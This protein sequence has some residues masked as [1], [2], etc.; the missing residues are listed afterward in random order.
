MSRQ[1]ITSSSVVAAVFLVFPLAAEDD[2]GE[3][4]FDILP[5][6]NGSVF[7]GQIV[8]EDRDAVYFKYVVR[9]P[10]SPT[11][12]FETTFSRDEV[13]WKKVRRLS[14]EERKE[15]A[16]RIEML[17]Q[18]GKREQA[19]MRDL[20]LEEIKF[21]GGAGW[22]YSSKYFRLETN[23]REELA[24]E[25]I[26][27]LEDV[28][29]AYTHRLGARRTPKEVTRIT[30]FRSV[31]DYQ[32]AIQELR[33]NILNPAFYDPV[34]NWIM[35]A[36]ALEQQAQE[37]DKL[38]QKHDAIL[39]DLEEQEKKMRKHY[40]GQPPQAMLAQF[41]QIR[42]NV[43][44]VNAEN[45]DAF[46]AMKRPL[47]AILY[48]E[49]FHAYLDNHVYPSSEMTVPRWLNEGLAQIFET[50]IVEAG[51]LRVGHVHPKRL[52]KI[53][54]ALKNKQIVPLKELLTSNAKPFSVHDLGDKQI[55]DRYF[56]TSWA[57]AYYLAFER[58]ALDAN[59]LD[60][61]VNTL[62]RGTDPLDAFHD[63]VGETLGEF[64]TKFH[65]FLRQLRPG[66]APDARSDAP[67]K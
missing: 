45:V 33:I 17:D 20:K 56:L 11:I 58:K 4:K 6:K 66:S 54:E 1:L 7:E 50:A 16:R 65:Q 49:A 64:E 48:H 44:A 22:A 28:Y 29:E 13:D 35:A 43:L 26:V 61:Y 8:A 59:A 21:N 57:L 62:S 30:L 31:E 34:K 63:L 42:R 23:V 2:G 47:L 52:E 5:L 15:L 37:L 41:W 36:S 51:R 32:K 14:E 67:K 25:L 9:K 39:Q 27:R 40:R 53:Q 55:A 10:G 3:W 46:E 60:E 38:R 24:R 12:V 18:G 19:R